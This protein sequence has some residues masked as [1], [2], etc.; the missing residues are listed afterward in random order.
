MISGLVTRASPREMNTFQQL[1]SSVN[2]NIRITSKSHI[3]RAAF[4]EGAE[5]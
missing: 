5:R 4:H 1:S 2:Y 3:N